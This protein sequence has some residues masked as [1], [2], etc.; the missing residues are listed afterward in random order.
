MGRLWDKY[1]NAEEGSGSEV[2]FLKELKSCA[3]FHV[4]R[5]LMWNH[6][7]VLEDNREHFMV[8]DRIS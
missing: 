8:E 5:V 4:V 3:S 2:A 7:S 6:F 1:I